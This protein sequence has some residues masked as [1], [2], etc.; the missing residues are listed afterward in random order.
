MEL[1]GSLRSKMKG[2]SVLVSF[3]FRYC[4]FRS[5]DD[6]LTLCESAGLV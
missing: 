4:I 2:G 6:F 3:I 1:M 5:I